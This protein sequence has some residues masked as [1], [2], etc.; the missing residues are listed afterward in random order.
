MNPWL[1]V[2]AV[3][4]VA[5]AAALFLKVLPP[6]LVLVFFVGGIAAVNLTL[7]RRVKNSEARPPRD[8][9]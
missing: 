6:L 3:F 7:R 5:I 4:G 9:G 1:R 8:S 2:L